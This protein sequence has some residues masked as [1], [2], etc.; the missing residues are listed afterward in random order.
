[1]SP[2]L[3]LER[4]KFFISPETD[5]YLTYPRRMEMFWT[6]HHFHEYSKKRFRYMLSDLRYTIREY[7]WWWYHPLYFPKGIRPLLRLTPIAMTR[8]QFY[9][10]R[11]EPST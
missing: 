6:H 1:M 10:L 11:Y 8:Q 3:M 7:D 5:I 2:W 9:R 4:L